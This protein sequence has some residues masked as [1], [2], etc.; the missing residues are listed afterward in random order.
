[1]CNLPGEHDNA[2]PGDVKKMR[3]AADDKKSGVTGRPGDS[4]KL[5]QR[6]GDMLMAQAEASYCCVIKNLIF[7][8]QAREFS[9]LGPRESIQKM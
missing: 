7:K 9:A 1:M 6:V 4:Q 8:M 2:K 3:Q 5:K